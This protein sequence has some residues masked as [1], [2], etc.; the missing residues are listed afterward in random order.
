MKLQTKSGKALSPIGI[1]TW[2][3]SSVF[4]ADPSAKYMGAQAV[5][6]NE[7]AEIDALRYS[8]EKGQ[9]HID[10]A[11]L[12]GAFYTD[13]VVGRAIAGFPREDLFIA[14]KLWKTSVGRGKVRPSVEQMLAK[15]GTDYIDLL[16]IHDAWDQWQDAIP[17]IDELIDQGVVRYFGVSNF[18]IEQMQE[19]RK[20]AKHPLAANQM[21]FNVLYKGEVSRAFRDF[22][23]QHDIQIVAYQPTKRQEVLGNDIVQAIAAAHNAAPAQVALAWLLQV[24]A[25]PIPKATNKAHIDENLKSTELKLTDEEIAKLEAL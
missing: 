5:H 14:D 9:N 19:A 10:C 17:Q 24:G 21:N 1:G 12:Y 18:T 6:G 2:N 20:I 11:E 15:L 8:L 13:E 22:C 16:Y 25:L 7:D 4:E 23:K 3:I